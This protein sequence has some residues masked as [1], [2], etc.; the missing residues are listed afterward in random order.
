M[1]RGLVSIELTT[2]LMNDV[3]IFLLLIASE[4]AYDFAEQAAHLALRLSTY[5]PLDGFTPKLI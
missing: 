3:T 1:P 5:L 4:F 2:E